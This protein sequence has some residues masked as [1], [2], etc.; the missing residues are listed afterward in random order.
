M[1]KDSEARLPVGQ[2]SHL[3]ITIS[4]LHTATLNQTRHSTLPNSA[5]SDTVVRETAGMPADCRIPNYGI[6]NSRVLISSSVKKTAT[7]NSA[8]SPKDSEARLPTGQCPRNMIS[9]CK[10]LEKRRYLDFPSDG[11]HDG[12][13]LVAATPF[14]GARACLTWKHVRGHK[15]GNRPASCLRTIRQNGVAVVITS[16]RSALQE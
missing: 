3:H 11:F 12:K 8:L 13:S 5:V 7:P 14:R 9:E 2:C 16:M 15:H 1:P 10:T 4:L 6:T